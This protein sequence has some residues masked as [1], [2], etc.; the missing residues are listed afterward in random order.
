MGRNKDSI[1]L[2]VAAAAVTLF[3]AGCA[4][5]SSSTGSTA[6]SAAAPTE[7]AAGSG[8]VAA[9]S[10]SVAAGSAAAAPATS[11]QPR[12]HP[13]APDFYKGMDARL[14]AFLHDLKQNMQSG[15]WKWILDHAERAH[16]RTLVTEGHMQT[17]EY[18]RYLF[19]IGMDYRARF[20]EM[21]SP[22]QYF[23][24]HDIQNVQYMAAISDGFLT[25]VYGYVY[26]KSGHKLDFAVDVLAKLDPMLLNGAYP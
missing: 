26:D 3:L 9:G 25:T 19:R 16:F 20:P 1:R 10:G 8:S 4:S 17:D 6:E 21:A 7:P 13:D 24:A 22:A 2:F 18:I 11:S 15:N 14:V 12:M 5:F 23:P